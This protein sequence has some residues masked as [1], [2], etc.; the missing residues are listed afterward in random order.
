M[1]PVFYQTCSIERFRTNN[2]RQCR[3]RQTE[4]L[5]L[6]FSQIRQG[7]FQKTSRQTFSEVK[8]TWNPLSDIFKKLLQSWA[9]NLQ[10]FE[11]AL[12]RFDLP[13]A[14]FFCET[15]QEYHRHEI[16][17]KY[18]TPSSYSFNK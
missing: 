16:P 15:V 6:T 18:I 3:S 5:P 9:R 17:S 11:K 14:S 7:V 12:H 2:V 13:S 8:R 1:T 10:L 4:K